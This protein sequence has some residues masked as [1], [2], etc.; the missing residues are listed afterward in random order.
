MRR[1]QCFL[2]LYHASETVGDH[3][4][5]VSRGFCTLPLEHFIPESS[6]LV[7]YRYLYG[8]IDFKNIK[9]G[10]IFKMVL[11]SV[12][13]CIF[14]SCPPTQ[15]SVHII[16]DHIS[17]Q[18]SRSIATYIPFASNLTVPPSSALKHA[19][20]C[21]S[22]SVQDKTHLKDKLKVITLKQTQSYKFLS[23]SIERLH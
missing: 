18:P 16:K 23:K 22:I 2:I 5:E 19:A 7:L 4:A 10:K 3:L 17:P 6:L 20:K 8:S 15:S 21:S 13:I 14:D 12:F 1:H 9:A 11:L